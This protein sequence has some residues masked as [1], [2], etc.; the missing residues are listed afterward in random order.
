MLRSIDS[1]VNYAR[2]KNVTIA[3]ETEGSVSKKDH[4]LLQ[5]P[6]EFENFKNIL[7]TMI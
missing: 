2:Q 3:I 7:T 4:L 6:K 5:E 1:I